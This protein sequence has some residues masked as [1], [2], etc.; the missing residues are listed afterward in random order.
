MLDW[1]R[2]ERRS[3]PRREFEDFAFAIAERRFRGGS[4]GTLVRVDGSGGG[5]CVEV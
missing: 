2:L 3:D 5:H 1:T 4:E